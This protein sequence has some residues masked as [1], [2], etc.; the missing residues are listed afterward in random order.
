[1]AMS[2]EGVVVGDTG[3]HA[4]TRV[5]QGILLPEYVDCDVKG[6]KLIVRVPFTGWGRKFVRGFAILWGGFAICMGVL[7]A[8]FGFPDGLVP[9]LPL[10]AAGA[11]VWRRRDLPATWVLR[12]G[13]RWVSVSGP[14]AWSVRR[15]PKDSVRI[16]TNLESSGHVA[17]VTVAGLEL[18]RSEPRG[19]SS[20]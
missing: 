15:V 3:T 2:N 16:R 8:A 20:F 14:T 10:L 7:L 9:G 6:D 17:R 11:L 19:V 4:S 1:M 18:F 13:S 5:W 12:P